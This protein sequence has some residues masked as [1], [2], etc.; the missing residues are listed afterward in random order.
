MLGDKSVMPRTIEE[1]FARPDHEKW[2][3][4]LEV[5]LGAMRNMKVWQVGAL[6]EGATAL[7][8]RMLFNIKQPSGRYK[9]RLVA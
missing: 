8:C 5:K 7:R 4:A 6:P 2:R 9:C 3:E 1:A